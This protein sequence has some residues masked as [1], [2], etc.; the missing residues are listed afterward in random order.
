MKLVHCLSEKVDTYGDVG[1]PVTDRLRD[2]VELSGWSWSLTRSRFDQYWQQNQS[3]TL[4]HPTYAG[5]PYECHSSVT[6]PRLLSVW[7]WLAQ[8]EE[9]RIAVVT[10]SKLLGF[11]DRAYGLLK[12]R[13]VEEGRAFNNCEAVFVSFSPFT[14]Q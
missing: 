1:R 5:R 11:P 2:N 3:W 9:Q 4:E 8:R 14:K 10:H 12:R 7:Q 6:G 13:A